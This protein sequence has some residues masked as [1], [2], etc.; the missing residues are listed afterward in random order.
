M[1]K[2]EK[3]IKV[4][5][6][7]IILGLFLMIRSYFTGK[8]ICPS[9]NYIGIPCPLCGMT[10]AYKSMLIFDIGQAFFNHPLFIVIPFIP[11]LYIEKKYKTLTIIG[12]IFILVWGI[13]LFL[14]FPDVIP[15]TP[16]R[17]AIIYKIYLF[18]RE[19]I[20]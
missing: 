12:I 18:L 17:N 2:Y 6:L 14:Y 11:Y 10:R 13:R 9:Y 3:L 8:S 5:G 4:Y 20:G 16:N 1:K 7:I 15:M 19:A